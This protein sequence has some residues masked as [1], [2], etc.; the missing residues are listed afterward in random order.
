MGSLKS[1]LRNK[2]PLL[3]QVSLLAIRDGVELPLAKRGKFNQE[4][5]SRHGNKM[6]PLSGGIFYAFRI[7]L[8]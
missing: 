2:H 6:P 4:K 5:T 8:L 7:S 3:H 1:Q